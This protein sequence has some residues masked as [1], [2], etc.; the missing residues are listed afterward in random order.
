M[1][2]LNDREL[3]ENYLNTL[4]ETM[5][6]LQAEILRTDEKIRESSNGRKVDK[7]ELAVKWG[8][9]TESLSAVQ[10][11]IIAVLHVLDIID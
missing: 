2:T 4:F 7:Y 11:K 5:D 8:K 9:I 1:P 10:S 3:I 6:S